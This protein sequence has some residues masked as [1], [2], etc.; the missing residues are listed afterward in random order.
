MKIRL[1]F[2][3]SVL[4]A[5]FATGCKT[6]ENNYREAYLKARERQTDT[7]DSITTAEFRASQDPR[8][9]TIDSVEL[10][11][12]TMPVA[13]SDKAGNPEGSAL[14]R[15]NV[16]VGRFK[17]IF[18]A[19]SMRE[20]LAAGGYS[21]A[22]VLYNGSG[23]YFVVACGTFVATEAAELLARV[24]ADPSLTLREPYP[25]ILRPSILAR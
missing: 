19:K 3:A 12:L 20:R 8:T 9:V 5:I 24:K 2:I 6:N 11:M 10:P 13:L 1:L 21:G 22:M 17:Q 16:V 25:Y 15:Y 14:M 4:L 18:N 23:E 7:G